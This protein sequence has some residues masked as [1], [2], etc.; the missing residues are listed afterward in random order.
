M[1]KQDKD[2]DLP[3]Y[4]REPSDED[5]AQ[6]GAA[7]ASYK[8]QQGIDPNKTPA[9]EDKEKAIYAKPLAKASFKEA[10]AEAR[11]SGDKTFEYMG[12]KYTTEVAKPKAPAKRKPPA[13]RAA[14]G[15]MSD[16]VGAKKGGKVSSA[17]SRGDGIAQ[18]GKTRGKMM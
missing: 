6:Q 16:V 11:A 3:D 13:G 4:E 1:K 18:R 8:V 15:Q 14:E 9:D 5:K 12:K 2:S 10:F 7:V 17:S